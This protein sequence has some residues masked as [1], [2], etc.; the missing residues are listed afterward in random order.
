MS[1]GSATTGNVTMSG[2][3]REEIES[4]CI[5]HAVGVL[6]CPARDLAARLGL[7]RE[8]ASAVAAG[9]EPLIRAGWIERRDEHVSLTD[10]GR[11]Q[12]DRRLSD[13][14]GRGGE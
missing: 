14:L 7:S 2:P 12:L 8:L 4:L 1:H 6:G 10:A 3:S 9:I 13:L 11:Q 5:L